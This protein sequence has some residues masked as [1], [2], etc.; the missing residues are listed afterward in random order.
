MG[1]PLSSP[2]QQR[3][4]KLREATNQ[5]FSDSAILMT[6]VVQGKH[7]GHLIN[8]I[9]MLVG[10][11]RCILPAERRLHFLSYETIV[12][13]TASLACR[14]QHVIISNGHSTMKPCRRQS[15]PH[16]RRPLHVS[17]KLS[18]T[19]HVTLIR[20]LTRST[21]C[22]TFRLGAVQLYVKILS[23]SLGVSPLKIPVLAIVATSF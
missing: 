13:P 6:M 14:T 16:D 21:D 7:S 9:S 18:S 3:L 2:T 22:F 15:P 17:T 19:C 10:Q 5:S 23:W 11:S 8:K 1:S 20:K 4:A 12:P